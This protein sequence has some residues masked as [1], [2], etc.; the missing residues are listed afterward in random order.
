MSIYDDFLLGPRRCEMPAYAITVIGVVAV[1]SVIIS[2]IF[3]RMKVLNFRTLLSVTLASLITALGLPALFSLVS[4]C[5]DASFDFASSTVT[6]LITVAAY[7][8]IVVILSMVISFIING[9]G[10]KK[11]VP[12]AS[13]SGA[14]GKAS[15]EADNYLEQIFVNFIGEHEQSGDVNENKPVQTAETNVTEAAANTNAAYQSAAYTAGGDESAAT[16]QEAPGAAVFEAFTEVTAAETAEEDSAAELPAA[17]TAAGMP[18]EYNVVETSEE[19]AS[20]GIAEMTEMVLEDSVTAPEPT[21]EA[22]EAT[23]PADDGILANIDENAAVMENNLEISVDS[24]E[25]IDKMG[26]ENIVH[27]RNSLTIEDCINEAFR[28]KGAGDFESAI[29]HHMYALDKKPNKELTF[30]IILDI[31]VMYKSL[32][33]QELALDILNSYY[34]TYGDTM[35]ISVKEEIRKNLTAVQA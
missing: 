17:D 1:S 35:D 13:E 12:D 15:A 8:L 6:L 30:W 25:N 20:T 14:S 27:N 7:L 10:A 23:I 9:T 5:M 18:G 2:L 28:L 19:D 24:N 3:Y 34:E 33:Q 32:G 22:N 29:L 31:C 4:S 11:Q 16:A 26:I 21:E